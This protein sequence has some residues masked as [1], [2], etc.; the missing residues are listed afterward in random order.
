[1]FRS[2]SISAY[3]MGTVATMNISGILTTMWWIYVLIMTPS[4]LFTGGFYEFVL[5]FFAVVIL[6]MLPAIFYKS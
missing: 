4:M 6:L 5:G 2:Y 1:M 3:S